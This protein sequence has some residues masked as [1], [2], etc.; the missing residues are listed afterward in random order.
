MFVNSI[1]V[2]NESEMLESFEELADYVL[3]QTD[4]FEIDGWVVRTSLELE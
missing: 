2:S 3:E 1:I 4:G